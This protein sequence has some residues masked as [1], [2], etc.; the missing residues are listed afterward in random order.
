MLLVIF[1]L[2]TATWAWSNGKYKQNL[3]KWC[4]ILFSK[5]AEWSTNLSSRLGT[6]HSLSQFHRS[7]CRNSS[8]LCSAEIQCSRPFNRMRFGSTM[9][10]NEKEVSNFEFAFEEVLWCVP[11][12]PWQERNRPDDGSLVRRAKGRNGFEVCVSFLFEDIWSWGLQWLSPTCCLTVAKT[13][14]WIKWMIFPQCFQKIQDHLQERA[15]GLLK[16]SEMKTSDALVRCIDL[17]TCKAKQL[18]IE[19]ELNGNPRRD[20]VP[21]CCFRDLVEHLSNPLRPSRTLS[22]PS[23]PWLCERK[24]K[25]HLKDH[26]QAKFPTCNWFWLH[27]FRWSLLAKG[28]G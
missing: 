4:Q 17:Q 19:R 7:S 24:R 26:F 2:N 18:F 11:M 23:I 9:S 6:E 3:A 13:Q 22:S 8:R 15:S 16:H 28:I 20:N 10:H 12:A 14:F 25:T 1:G 5:K 27:L 21:R